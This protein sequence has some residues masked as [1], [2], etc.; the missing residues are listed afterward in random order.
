L[1]LVCPFAY[2]A[3]RYQQTRDASIL[4][5]GHKAGRE[6]GYCQLE[7]LHNLEVLPPDGFMIACFSA[8]IHGASAGWTRAVAILE[9]SDEPE[10]GKI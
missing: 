4:W 9:E 8:K 2:T 5:E 7:K 10:R 3:E 1:E 6:I